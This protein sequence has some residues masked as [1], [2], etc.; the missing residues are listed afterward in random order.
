M[1]S[2]FQ[3]FDAGETYATGNG[4]SEMKLKSFVRFYVLILDKGFNIQRVIFTQYL[5]SKKFFVHGKE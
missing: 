2:N 1:D 4:K 3:E 5:S